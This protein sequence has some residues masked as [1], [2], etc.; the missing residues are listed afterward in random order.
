[1]ESLDSALQ[2][3][4]E[5]HATLGEIEGVLRQRAAILVDRA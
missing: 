4:S 5:L 2:R 3:L 1:M